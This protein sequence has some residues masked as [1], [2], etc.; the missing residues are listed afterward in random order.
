MLEP[1]TR[2]AGV[3][4]AMIVSGADGLMVEEQLLEGVPGGAVAALAASLARRLGRA[5]AAAGAGAPTFWHLQADGGALLAVPAA[6]G[7]LVVAVAAP[8]VN[9]GLVRLE[10][11]RAAEGA[12]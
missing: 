2:I 1:V 4:G 9:I 12:G 5:L 6:G 11:L 10:L 8:D 3:R 7:L